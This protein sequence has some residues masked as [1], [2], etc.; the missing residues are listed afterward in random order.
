MGYNKYKK[1]RPTDENAPDAFTEAVKNTPEISLSLRAGLQALKKNNDAG[2]VEA[3]D[4]RKLNGSVDIDVTTRDLYPE[5][6]RWDYVIGYEGKAYFL[7]VH[8]ANT[9]EVKI[10]LKK[11]DWLRKWLDSK[12][13]NLKAISG[14]NCFYWV[15]TN[16]F[17]IVSSSPQARK[18][19]QSKVKHIGRVFKLPPKP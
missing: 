18:L 13:P 14:S 9:S 12:A 7:E 5:D 10:V 15:S 6:S 2:R 3:T 4:N 17:Q 16:D 11:A 1:M 19:A 8:S